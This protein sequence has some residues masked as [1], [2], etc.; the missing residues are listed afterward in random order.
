MDTSG[1]SAVLPM[2]RKTS[3]GIR[4]LWRAAQSCPPAIEKQEQA[5]AQEERW[6]VSAAR[7][8]DLAGLSS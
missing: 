2:L 7:M 1:K 8:L 4:G 3:A 6:S 5:Q